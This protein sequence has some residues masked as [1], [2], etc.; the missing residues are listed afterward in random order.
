MHVWRDRRIEEH[1]GNWTMSLLIDREE[2]EAEDGHFDFVN[3][4][5]DT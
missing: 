1:K 3:E 2:V 4:Q 5:M